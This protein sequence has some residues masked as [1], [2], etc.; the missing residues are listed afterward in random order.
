MQI[1]D[2]ALPG[3]KLITP[4]RFGDNRGF[5]SETYN[6]EAFAQAGIDAVFLQDNHSLSQ[7]RGTVR[8]LHYQIAPHGQAKLVRVVK[9]AILDVAVD[10]R[11]GSPT[12]GQHAASILSAENWQQMYIPIGF[13]HGF[14]TLEPATEV[15]YKVTGLYAPM[16]ER[17]LMWND[18]DLGID[19]PI[20]AASA[21]LSGK[22]TTHPRLRDLADIFEIEGS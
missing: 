2:G 14:C 6:A 1:A 10:I 13:A 21:V 11:R 12:F 7:D 8:G 16:A 17:G 9:G 22:D 15:Q 19:W 5:F 20:D 18:P 4:R 3:I